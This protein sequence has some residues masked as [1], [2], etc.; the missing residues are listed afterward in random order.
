VLVRYGEKQ[1]VQEVL[2]QSRFYSVNDARLHFGL[3]PER[4]ADI[5]V[6]WPN[7]FRASF[8]AV[9]VD[10]LITLKEGSGIVPSVGWPEVRKGF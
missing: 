3:G 7:G 2:S 9:A 10:R 4:V 1:Q 8:K 6:R 5:D